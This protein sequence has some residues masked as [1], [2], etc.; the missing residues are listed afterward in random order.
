[1]SHPKHD[2]SKAFVSATGPTSHALIKSTT[3]K[4][5]ENVQLTSSYSLE[6]EANE[7]ET[8]HGPKNAGRVVG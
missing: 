8:P 6:K 2:L 4:N 7:P 3:L 1:M 5:R